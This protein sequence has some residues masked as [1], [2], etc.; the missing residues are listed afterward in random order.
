MV[1]KIFL[2]EDIDPID[3]YGSRNS[4]LNLI[5]SY[6]PKLKVNARGSE[7]HILGEEEIINQFKKK[8]GK[9]KN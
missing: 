9:K 2:L 3:L 4:K 5:K 8:L 7:L 6:F 1:D